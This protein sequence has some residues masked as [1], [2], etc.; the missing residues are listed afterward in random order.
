MSLF[1][2]SII[3]ILLCMIDTL[4]TVYIL[5]K[6]GRE[7]NPVIRFFMKFAGQEWWILKFGMDMAIILVC[8]IFDNG[9][10]ALYGATGVM[11]VVVIWNLWQI[12]RNL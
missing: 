11:F 6:G 4:T 2:L 1:V 8:S 3:F 10:Y 5:S 12:K 9:I 7:L